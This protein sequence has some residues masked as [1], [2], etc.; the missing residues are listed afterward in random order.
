MVATAAADV[1][2]LSG[3]PKPPAGNSGFTLRTTSRLVE[4]PVV[5]LDKKGQPIT[6]MKP[7]ELQ[8]YDAG[9]KQQVSFFSQAGAG[10]LTAS[11][12]KPAHAGANS[13]NQEVTN[14]PSAVS[15]K[16]MAPAEA[17]TTVLLIDS[18]NVAFADLNNAR[19]EILRFLKAV[20]A[21]ERVGLY[22]LHG[23]GFQIL[24]EPTDD[25][26]QVASKLTAWMPSAQ[27]LLRA[28]HE[29][30]RNRQN[31]EYVQ[32]VTDLLHANGNT[33]D[34]ESDSFFP[35]DPQLRSLGDAPE[36]D[37][38]VALQGV[39]RRLGAIPGRKTLVW[40]ASDNVLADFSD[41]APDQEKGDKGLDP[42]A[43]RARETLNEAHVS[44]YPLDVSQLEAGGVGAE[45]HSANVEL[46]PTTN[47]QVEMLTLPPELQKEAGEALAKSKRNA[48]PGRVMAQLQQDTHP[49]QEI[50]V[51]LAQATGGRALRRAGDIAAE[52]NSIVAD[53]RAAYLLSFAPDTPADGKYHSIT[54]KT[55]RPGISLRYRN[56]Y[57]YSEEPATMK[58]R[59][60][61]AVWQ[62]RDETGIGL[63]ATAVQEAKGPAVRLTIAAA[64][65][66]LDLDLAQQADRWTDKLDVFLVVRDDS[67]LHAKV[68]GRRL[69]LAL[70][71]ATYQQAM[72]EG[73]PVEESLPKTPPGALVRLIVIDENSRR[74]GSVTLP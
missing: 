16:T 28:Q 68:A 44:L 45:Q 31:V 43:L 2:D 49:I 40:V 54:V 63:A 37:A 42:L 25:H 74:M 69:A 15:A 71:P 13:E 39:G 73:L 19:Q 27:D 61:E 70:K 3:E 17:H 8:V 10:T 29:E 14:R 30:G 22:I 11:G 48:Y 64:D 35:V 7:D 51:Q 72:K 60:R 56:G 59:F 47:E 21:D 33:P 67:G 32:H 66:D 62:P 46:K 6:D 57:L 36:R 5:A 26:A 55:T 23:F 58:D 24:L 20:A 4:V 18:G 50:F 34:A 12:E 1:P 52:L 9:R 53:G 38:L 41:K 65:L